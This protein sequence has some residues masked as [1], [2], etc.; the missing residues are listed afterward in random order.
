METSAEFLL[1]SGK[2]M[3]GCLVVVPTGHSGRSLR[4]ELARQGGSVLPPMV[5]TPG[6]LVNVAERGVAEPWEEELAWCEVLE[7]FPDHEKVAAAIPKWP[8]EVEALAAELANLRHELSGAGHNIA[9]ASQA[10]TDS[11]ETER[12]Q[13]LA[14]LEHELAA[15]LKRWGFISRL[16]RL[17]DRL[18][19]SPD[20]REIVIAGVTDMPRV[21]AEQLKRETRRVSC[22]IP[23]PENLAELFDE[24]GRPT[25]DWCG[26]PSV[27]PE[28][29]KGS[30]SLVADGRMAAEGALKRV[31]DAGSE[32]TEVVIG[33]V[34]EESAPRLVERFTAA[35]WTAFS[36]AASQ[37]VTGISRFLS[38]W[39]SWQ[40]EASVNHLADLLALPETSLLFGNT[41]PAS[42][43]KLAR[44]RDAEVMIT[45][46]HLKHVLHSNPDEGLTE[47]LRHMLAARQRMKN[48]PLPTL[49][50][51]ASALGAPVEFFHW[52]ERAETLSGLVNRKA[53]LWLEYACDALPEVPIEKPDERV[54][55]V[56]GWLELLFE[57]GLHL[58]LIG[59][60]E[61][62]VPSR[63]TENAWIGNQAAARLGLP[64]REQRHARDA[65]LYQAMTRMRLND[66]R[67]DVIVMKTTA[68][69]DVLKPSR[70]LLATQGDELIK[71][72]NILFRELEPPDAGLKFRADWKWRTP[73][74]E[75]PGTLAVT[76]FRTYLQCPFRF[77]LSQ[78]LRARPMET[79]RIEWNAREFGNI[80]HNLLEAFAKD[81]EA[82]ELSKS[83]AIESW[84]TERLDTYI[85]E[86]FGRQVPLAIRLQREAMSRRL[87]WLARQQACLAAEG[88]RILEAEL[89]IEIALNGMI[90]KARIDRVDQHRDTGEIRVIDYKTG[91]VDSA[92]KAHRSSVTART[93]L[94]GHIPS[95]S[96]VVCGNKRW[97]DLQLPLYVLGTRDQYQTLPKPCYFLLGETE[98]KVRLDCWENFDGATLEAATECAEWVVGQINKREFWPPAEKAKGRDYE[99]LAA[100]RPLDEVF[101][102]PPQR[103]PAA[104]S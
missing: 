55:D 41:M 7:R 42:A 18:A 77:Y 99:A 27:W 52:L 19:I 103:A 22:L 94:P 44:L 74:A 54:V 34:L 40:N 2:D 100:G 45:S 101:D 97:L 30:V 10:L 73:F 49:H 64:T 83:E 6:A 69:G 17:A 21:V 9:T 1:R 89:P 15:T 4:H 3:S 26:V 57:R 66:G 60:N 84:L 36:P 86:H 68:S 23:A 25:A 59:M 28:K 93:V 71:R 98:E 53:E 20:V 67:T 37:L 82:K 29:D 78:I 56:L 33:A 88:W 51:M 102:A 70:I 63:G 75:L 92:E 39:R 5:T 80:P 16:R 104:L 50:A 87:A 12:W 43:T 79:G 95:D 61:G 14:L 96:P 85:L 13:A 90:I 47:T 46:E 65:F 58:V 48:E 24:I 31:A 91:K 32:A 62:S 72:V 38:A 76:S 11:P 8:D 81:D 35:G